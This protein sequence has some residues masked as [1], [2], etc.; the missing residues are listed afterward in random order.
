[1]SCGVYLMPRHADVLGCLDYDVRRT[2]ITPRVNAQRL[3]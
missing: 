1:M 3:G 2:A